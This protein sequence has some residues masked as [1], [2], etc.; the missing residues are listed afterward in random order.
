[1]FLLSVLD[2]R[3]GGRGAWTVNTQ[4]EQ[5]CG[6]DCSTLPEMTSPTL[7]LS[8]AYLAGDSICWGSSGP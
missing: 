6:Q 7:L 2:S 1:M 5:P 8:I 3:W 4:V